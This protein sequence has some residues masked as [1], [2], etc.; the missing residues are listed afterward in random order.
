[1]NGFDQRSL[2]GSTRGAGRLYFRSVFDVQIPSASMEVTAAPE[3]GNRLLDH[4]PWTRSEIGPDRI[5]LF[6]H[7]H[8]D[9]RL[10]TEDLLQ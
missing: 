4:R 10:R 2:I 3:F 8:P 7:D 5:G 1:L 6:N 9:V